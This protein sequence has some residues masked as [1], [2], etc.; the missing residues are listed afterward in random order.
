M[1]SFVDEINRTV[2]TLKSGGVILYPTDTVWGI[3]CDATNKEAVEKIYKIKQ[4]T[5]SKSLIVLVDSEQRLNRY[6]REVSALAWDLIEFSE[7]PLTIIYSDPIGLA[8]NV[9]AED[10]SVGMRITKDEFCKQLIFKFGKPIISTSANVS[11]Q[12][13]PRN[14][15]EISKHILSEVD[16]I[17]NLRQNETSHSQSS[18]IIKLG[19][20]GEIKIIRK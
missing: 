15:N 19:L 17:V 2:D 9:I 10:G 11:G 13:T 5:E 16:Y 3:G 20:T 1:N 18:T 4:R 6:V 8:S 14:F 7:R 12:T